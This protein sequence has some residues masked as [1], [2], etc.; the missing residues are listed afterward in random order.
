MQD[1]FDLQGSMRYIQP[2]FR[3]GHTLSALILA[4]VYHNDQ[5]YHQKWKTI[6][7]SQRESLLAAHH[8]Q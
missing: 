7:S 5:Q 6:S 8:L 3:A 4:T 2:S 1:N